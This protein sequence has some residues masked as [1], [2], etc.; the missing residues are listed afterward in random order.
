MFDSPGKGRGL[1]ATK[2]LLS[3]DVLFSEPP[4][5]AVVFDR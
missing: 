1:R 3:G 4:F 2:E 5:A